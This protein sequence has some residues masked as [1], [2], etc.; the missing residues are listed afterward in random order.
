MLSSIF[1][2]N[3]ISRIWWG[4]LEIWKPNRAKWGEILYHFLYQQLKKSS[5]FVLYLFGSWNQVN[6]GSSKDK[7]WNLVPKL[8]LNQK[9]HYSNLEPQET[10]V[11][12]PCLIVF[13]KFKPPVP[14]QSGKIFTW[15]KWDLTIW[16]SS[17]VPYWVVFVMQKNKSN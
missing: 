16:W 2:D 11:S 14:C 8:G 1:E 17:Y 9:S 4:K 3:P 15:K 5:V 7:M 10:P 13:H 6:F 12:I